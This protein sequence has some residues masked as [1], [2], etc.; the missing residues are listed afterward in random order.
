MLTDNFA[1]PL[2]LVV[3]DDDGHAE[4]IQRSFEDA[5]DEYRL[6]IVGTIGAAKAAIA[7]FSP[8]LVLCDYRLPDGEGG[9]LVVVADGMWPVIMMTSFG[10][11]QVAVA[12]IKGGA[13]DY[14]VKSP[15]M[16]DALAGTVAYALMSWEL[17]VARRQVADS[18]ATAKKDWERTFDA[19]PDLIS[20]ID[21]HHTI[22]RAN[23]AMAERC[24][25]TPG[26][27]VGRKCFE[28]IGGFSLPHD[29][30]PHARLLQGALTGTIEIEEKSFDGFFD[31]TV[32]PLY[33]ED[34]C[35][36]ASVHIMRD[37][38]GRKIAEEERLKLEQQFIQTQKLESL[39]V[40]AGGIAHDFNNILTII[41]GHCFMVKENFG[42]EMSDKAHI[43]K[44]E[45]A[46]NRA[47]DLCRQMLAYAG[48]SPLLSVQI[49]LWQLVDDMVKMLQSALKKNVT[50]QLDLKRDVPGMSGD[51]AQLQQVV[52]NLIINAAEAIGD[53]NGTIQV[54]LTKL[55]VAQGQS[56]HDFL[57]NSINAGSY[58]CLEVSDNGC[59]MDDEIQKRVFEPFFTTKFTGRGLG[60]SAI[61]GIIHSH[62]GALQL[63]SSP[64]VGTTFKVYL[65]LPVQATVI[66]TAHPVE[67]VPF[68]KMGGTVLLVDDEEALRT[69]G[70][71]LLN[72][73]GFATITASNG[74]EALDIYREC[75]S[76]ICLVLLDFIMPERGGAEVF[77]ALRKL[78]PRLP[79]V[80]CSGYNNEIIPDDISRDAY[81]A[82][83]QKP[84][85]PDALRSALLHLLQSHQ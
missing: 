46:A 4:L 29:N 67:T 5:P 84:Y 57:G 70:A 15:K 25:V 28:V 2:I 40:L 37:I 83:V 9:E 52:M 22:T 44:I 14:I 7:R 63:F 41:L 27:L 77:Y 31:V 6:D 38:T 72:A 21:I 74:T 39:G 36:T 71:V 33:D 23:K 13:Q 55:M 53:Q 35:I 12:A 73:M 58:A 47:A 20:I 75:G 16:F 80:L 82:F 65:P 45:V 30:C 32:S 68:G 34:G 8:D 59:G 19:V 78:S 48:N 81:Y 79:I 49:N 51:N 50:I 11:E 17:V 3:E 1:S 18:I 42:S 76:C 56:F 10:S 54:V 85:K 69:I 61:L 43:E 60:M 26:E 24:G 64:G 66:E 62:N